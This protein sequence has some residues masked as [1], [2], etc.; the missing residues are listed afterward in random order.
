MSQDTEKTFEA[1]LKRYLR[2]D[3]SVAKVS[4][5]CPD[6]NMVS[7]Y[8]E[9]VLADDSRADFEKHASSCVRCQQE[10][11]LLVKSQDTAPASSAIAWPVSAAKSGWLATLQ[12]CLTWFSNVGPKPVLAVLAVMLISG[13][14][15][16]ELFQREWQRRETATDVARTIP[17]DR[18]VAEEDR[19][20]PSVREA[21]NG[22]AEAKPAP[23]EVANEKV[24]ANQ[25]GYLNKAKKAVGADAP[26]A[27]PND[28]LSKD[29][30]QEKLLRDTY[31]PIPAESEAGK[32][33]QFG[34]GS[35][36][37]A[38][39][40]AAAGLPEAPL[41]GASS[42]VARRDSTDAKAPEQRLPGSKRTLVTMP[43]APQNEPVSMN[44]QRAVADEAQAS[45]SIRDKE[46]LAKKQANVQE[47][48]ASRVA[49]RKLK[50]EATVKPKEVKGVAGSPADE[51]PRQLRVAEK[52]F[53]LR[54]NVWT[55]LSIE[56]KYARQV[57]VFLYKNSSNY[58]E[59][60][61]PLSAYSS[62][63]SRDEECLLEHQGKIYHIKNSR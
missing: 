60:V 15:G 63:L 38:K 29:A 58:R 2:D 49:T 1:L 59:Q 55:D 31:S 56:E 20:E 47:L 54:N 43:A 12:T 4:T 26:V 7:A 46:D 34:S 17:Q 53:E 5:E 51:E 11:S 62:V 19:R 27:P 8:L 9:G 25:E 23:P 3:R 10:L 33:V 35:G 6:E 41:P 50:Q 37:L 18:S 16:V 24:R 28:A 57:D 61:K 36:S 42:T 39:Q 30:D 22:A 44:G 45:T 48:S 21:E 14:V 52:I 13:Y 32:P 40:S